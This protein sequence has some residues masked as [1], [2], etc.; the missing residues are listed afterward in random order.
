MAVALGEIVEV[1]YRF[2]DGRCL[3]HPAVV[4]STGELYDAEDGMFYAVLISSKNHHPQ[5]T[6]EIKNEW[7]T[8]PLLKKSYF[9][10]HIMSFFTEEDITQRYNTAVRSPYVDKIISKT[11]SSIFG[12]DI[13]LE[14]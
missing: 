1:S 7:L 5:Y 12:W 9:V 6:L 4:V 11:I 14:E 2:P 8:K 10:T 13:T 3:V